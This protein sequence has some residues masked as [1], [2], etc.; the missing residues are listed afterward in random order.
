M[1]LLRTYR[2]IVSCFV[3]LAIAGLIVACKEKVEI[4][5]QTN[6]KDETELSLVQEGDITNMGD[7]T[8]F[9]T[10]ET[11]SILITKAMKELNIK[12]ID[13]EAKDIV[14][15]IQGKNLYH[16]E[17]DNGYLAFGKQKRRSP[18]S[19]DNRITKWFPVLAKQGKSLVLSG[20]AHNRSTWQFMTAEGEILT[21]EGTP[22]K[23]GK[24]GDV[25]QEKTVSKVD[26]PT[27]AVAARVY[28]VNYKES[29]ADLLDD[30]LQIEYGS[31]PTNY[32]NTR[33]N[34]ISLP[35]MKMNSVISLKGS[36]WS[37]TDTEA[38]VALDLEAPEL[39]VGTTLSIAA[40]TACEV[41]VTWK[42]DSNIIRTGAYGVRWNLNDSNPVCERVGDAVGLH[43]NA[44]MGEAML[45][46]YKNDF[47]YI[48]P[49]SDIKICAVKVLQDGSR[50]ITYSG[51]KG[52]A[53]DGSAGNI[54]VE[55]PKFYCKREIVDNYEYLWVSPTKQEGFVL[56]PSFITSKGE[57]DTI[58]IGAYLSSIVNNKLASVSKSFPLIK[59]SYSELQKL[60]ENS[61]GFAEC[62]LLSI[63]TAQ[64][65]Y[66]VETAVLDSQSVF[67]GNVNMP[68]LLKDKT[69]SYYAVSSEEETNR[70]IVSKT[71]MTSK[72]HLGDA[73]AVISSWEVFDNTSEYQRE[74]TEINDLGNETLEIKF[75][76]KPVNIIKQETGITC[77]PA[78]NGET[79]MI[80]A[81]TG[82][83]ASYS[84]Q[85]S[86][87]YRGIENLWG[88][89]SIFLD[90][91][92]VKNSRLFIDYPD[93]R[94]TEIDYTLPVQNV[95]LSAK[96][97]GSPT[98]MIVRK[99]GYDKS[100]PLIMF[101]SEI[102]NGALT[103]SYYCDSW[104]NLAE[105]DVTYVLTYGGAWDNKGYAGVF[106]FR[107]TFTEKDVL[108]YNGSRIMLR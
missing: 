32:Q 17:Y 53:L 2:K 40:S 35:S 60:I 58:Y 38:T 27:K 107:A 8:I 69:T 64:R 70:I 41:Q 34:K 99:M 39:Q 37:I 18:K 30:R 11:S 97:F 31:V 106:N 95:Q 36:N 26:I 108:P 103:S 90:R 5:S 50:R 1:K 16:G 15:T 80:P 55:I 104:Y 52:F 75:T 25:L 81:L 73:V 76:G 29:G 84:G 24:E 88:N 54:M 83:A 65:L 19:E 23:Y 66:L 94:T 22:R 49:W 78:K 46:P 68:Y 93:N 45:T 100:N 74:I 71:K 33:V 47:D 9:N 67:S 43:F 6:S 21:E 44:P 57:V 101:P 86:F 72:F 85:S 61:D 102:G 28:F 105:K 10:A 87:K 63:L 96:Q 12:P 20:T 4:K 98:N 89:V 48:Y 51:T 77:I 3:L 59:K 79:D 56:D 13:G 91:A 92:Y 14:I 7:V 42:E 82:A 62:D